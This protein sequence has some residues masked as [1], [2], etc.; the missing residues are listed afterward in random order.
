[1]PNGF[2]GPPRQANAPFIVTDWDESERVMI[3]KNTYQE[4]FRDAT[5]FLGIYPQGGLLQPVKEGIR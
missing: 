5:V 2:W 4:N 1:M 3:A